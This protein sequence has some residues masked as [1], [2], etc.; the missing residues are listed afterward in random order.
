L[1]AADFIAPLSF[2]AGTGKVALVRS[3]SAIANCG[4][5]SVVSLIGYGLNT[6]TA[7]ADGT[8]VG[9]SSNLSTSKAA[10]RND[11]GCMVTGTNS[12]EFT[13]TNI[14]SN[15]PPR[16]SSSSSFTC[17]ST[18]CPVSLTQNETDHTAEADYCKTLS[19]SPTGLT[20]GELYENGVTTTGVAPVNVVAQAGFGPLT[21]NP[22][23]QPGWTWTNA[24]YV[25]T[26]NNNA[27]YTATLA[28]PATS[29]NF[30]TYRFSVDNGSTWTY[31]DSN[32]AGSNINPV[33]VFETTQLPTVTTP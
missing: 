26:S 31:C 16:N 6:S 23:N 12:S 15:T 4:D 20:T 9:T 2:G 7:C 28:L 11:S 27:E 5:S 33:L 18:D 17:N 29:T 10:I 13:V 1:P 32:G 21:A 14:T 30:V 8:P 3:T 25:I 24:T 19:T 22:E